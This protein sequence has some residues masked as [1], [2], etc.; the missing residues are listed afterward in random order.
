MKETSENP[1]TKNSGIIIDRKE[2]ESEEKRKE[3]ES[4]IENKEKEIE[5]KEHERRENKSAMT[6]VSRREEK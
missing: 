2:I 3:N 5:R 4:V 6:L 1:S